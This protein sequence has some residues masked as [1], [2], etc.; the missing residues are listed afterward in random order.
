MKLERNTINCND[1][2]GLYDGAGAPYSTCRSLQ[3]EH[4]LVGLGLWDAIRSES[5][6]VR[7]R[8]LHK[9]TTACLRPSL[10]D[11]HWH[12]HVCSVS[13]AYTKLRYLVISRT[14]RPTLGQ[15]WLTCPDGSGG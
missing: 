12:L 10:S 9:L 3:C 4:N 15:S 13:V 2:S 11:S 6:G 14:A 8:S 7:R 1:Q 5:C